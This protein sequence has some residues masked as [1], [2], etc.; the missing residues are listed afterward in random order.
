[1]KAIAAIRKIALVVHLSVLRKELHSWAV[2]SLAQEMLRTD[3][4]EHLSST[5][6]QRMPS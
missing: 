1:M 5:S 2:S 4:L 6:V 3:M